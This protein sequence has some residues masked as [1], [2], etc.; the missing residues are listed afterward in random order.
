MAGWNCGFVDFSAHLEY[1]YRT[2]DA[3]LASDITMDR[4]NYL[5]RNKKEHVMQLPIYGKFIELLMQPSEFVQQFMV[6]HVRS[7]NH[8]IW[9]YRHMSSFTGAPSNRTFNSYEELWNYANYDVDFYGNSPSKHLYSSVG[10]H[11]RRGDSCDNE[12]DELVDIE[13]VGELV[14]AQSAKG[15]KRPCFSINLYMK[16]LHRLR[17][18]YNVKRVFLSTDDQAMVNH[19]IM[20][21]PAFNWVLV[22][23]D[24]SLFD[25]GLGWIEFRNDNFNEQILLLT[26]SDLNLLSFGDVFLGA[27]SSQY[28]KL[29]YYAI[30]GRSMSVPPFVSMDVPLMCEPYDNCTTSF[31]KEHQSDE[32]LQY[33]GRDMVNR[34]GKFDKYATYIDV[35]YVIGHGFQSGVQ[36]ALKETSS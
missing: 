29:G 11:V 21:E 36:S 27:F 25:H 17:E 33:K 9:E 28:S 5:R 8:H 1:E 12:L 26:I 6:S 22:Q 7:I 14:Y 32:W 2:D 13:S 30:A 31:I 10:M 23:S 24:R 4:L 15:E 18:L 3:Q 16:M 35:Q 20:N 34:D 19:A